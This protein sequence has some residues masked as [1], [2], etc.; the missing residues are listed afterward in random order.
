MQFYGTPI[1]PKFSDDGSRLAVYDARDL[2]VFSQVLHDDSYNFTLH[3]A[4]NSSCMNDR[5]TYQYP[6]DLSSDGNT[7]V[8]TEQKD[9]GLDSL[10]G[11]VSR[12]DTASNLESERT[13]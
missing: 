5:D 8:C 10:H 12:W 9:Y 1:I 3:S 2:W 7:I 4:F 6:F 13:V 11:R